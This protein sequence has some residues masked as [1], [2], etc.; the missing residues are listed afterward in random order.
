MAFDYCVFN[1]PSKYVIYPGG[2]VV[3]VMIIGAVT[4][5]ELDAII[6]R[7]KRRGL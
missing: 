3:V 4:A 5:T 6:T 7:V 1:S 2:R